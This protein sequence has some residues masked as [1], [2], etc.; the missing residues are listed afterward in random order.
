L[1]ARC[2]SA[3]PGWGRTA[4]EKLSRAKPRTKVINAD[5]KPLILRKGPTK[6]AQLDAEVGILKTFLDSLDSITY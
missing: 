3:P 2:F 6:L 5:S 1:V 4:L